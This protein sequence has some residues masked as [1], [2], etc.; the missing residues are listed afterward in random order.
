[1]AEARGQFGKP[2][3]RERPSLEALIRRL[4]QTVTLDAVAC[5]TV[6]FKAQSLAVIRRQINAIANLNT[7]YSNGMHMR[8]Y[9]YQRRELYEYSSR[10]S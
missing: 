8:V 10:H 1:V 6:I 3:E 4:V 9:K 7:V 2:E 5:V